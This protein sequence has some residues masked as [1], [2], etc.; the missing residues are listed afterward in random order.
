MNDRVNRFCGRVKNYDRYR[1]D[2][3]RQLLELLPSNVQFYSSS[4]VADIGAGTGKL[5]KIFLENGNKVY[6]IE[7]NEEMLEVCVRSYSGFSNFTSL[8]G[9]AEA[10]LLKGNSVDLVTVGQAAALV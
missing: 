2:Y 7:P 8:P 3:P 10:T 4:V 1:P 5:T 9:H 6:A